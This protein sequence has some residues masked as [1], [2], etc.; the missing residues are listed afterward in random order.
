MCVCSWACV[1]VC[2]VRLKGRN[3]TVCVDKKKKKISRHR[4]AVTLGTDSYA[5]KTNPLNLALMIVAKLVIA[6]LSWPDKQKKVQL[7]GQKRENSPWSSCKPD[8]RQS[9]KALS[10]RRLRG[11]A[12]GAANRR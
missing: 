8:Y 12:R 10:L 2:I 3:I 5:K 4:L 1:Q 9:L 7:E 6:F 11:G